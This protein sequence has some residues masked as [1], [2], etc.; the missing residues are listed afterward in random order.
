MAP[1]LQSAK[2]SAFEARMVDQDERIASLN[3]ERPFIWLASVSISVL[4]FCCSSGGARHRF[5]F[6]ER[7]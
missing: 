5:K 4:A 7:T 1:W 2:I 6:D 3:R